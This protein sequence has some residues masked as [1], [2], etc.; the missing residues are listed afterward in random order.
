MRI[1]EAFHNIEIAAQVKN[2]DAPL[3]IQ[4]EVV[5]RRSHVSAMELGVLRHDTRENSIPGVHFLNYSVP[6]RIRGPSTA[7]D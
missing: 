5:R 7:T 6:E 1:P 4:G 2:G 3:M